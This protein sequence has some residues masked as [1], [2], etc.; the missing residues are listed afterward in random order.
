V[1]LLVER[2]LFTQEEMFGR[3]GS[4]RAQAEPQESH[5]IEEHSAE[6][7]WAWQPMTARACEAGHRCG[8]P[9]RRG[10]SLLPLV[11]AQTAGVQWRVLL[12]GSEAALA[13]GQLILRK[14]EK[15]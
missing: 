2:G 3:E 4:R 11:S 6:H 14:K 12:S 8:A 5:G 7:A 13:V 9:G 1:V 10:P 15:I